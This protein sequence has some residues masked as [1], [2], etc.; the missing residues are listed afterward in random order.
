MDTIVRRICRYVR[1]N[2]TLWFHNGSFVHNQSINEKNINIFN[3][4]WVHFI[5]KYGK[6]LI[7]F[8]YFSR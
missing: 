1:Y 3:F 4:R 5:Y 2:Y 7:K 8:A 6:E